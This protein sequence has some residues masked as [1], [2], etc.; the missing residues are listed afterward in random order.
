[1]ENSKP[2]V[3]QK[4]AGTRLRDLS[5][6]RREN[7]KPSNELH[8]ILKESNNKDSDQKRSAH[9]RSDLEI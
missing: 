9:S 6:K 3:P 2:K 1:M 5:K 8:E 4:G 7:L